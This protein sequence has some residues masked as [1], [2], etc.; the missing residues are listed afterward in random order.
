MNKRVAVV[1]SGG[2]GEGLMVHGGV[3]EVLQE[4]FTNTAREIVLLA[5]CSAGGIMALEWAQRPSWSQR[6]RI[7]SILLSL[8]K[9][10]VFGWYS[11]QIR[12]LRILWAGVEQLLGL[13]KRIN[14]FLWA[15]PYK[16]F[17]KKTLGDGYFSN[18]AIPVIVVGAEIVSRSPFIISAMKQIKI[19]VAAFVT[20]AQAPEIEPFE[21]GLEK[22]NDGGIVAVAPIEVAL[23]D[24]SIEEIWAVIVTKSTIPQPVNGILGV[25][26]ATVHT[27]VAD[28][29]RR[30]I[31]SL[32]WNGQGTPVDGYV[33][34]A[35]QFRPMGS[36]L[37][38]FKHK[39]ELYDY[40][41]RT[42]RDF[43]R[44]TPMKLRRL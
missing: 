1:M 26:D 14:G 19:D 11:T 8:K 27:A 9:R 44:T 40:G 18:T 30:S 37:D 3:R 38:F 31:A 24:P 32:K 28:N 39:K 4:H 36:F 33:L 23:G 22:Y 2:G 21:M 12:W 34:Y 10:D 5:G 42:A 41:V 7:T 13:K 16:K 15:R 35:N 6:K 25:L 43:I 17:L 29:L 20:S